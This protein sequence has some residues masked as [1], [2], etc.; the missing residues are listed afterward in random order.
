[1]K[2]FAVVGLMSFLTI[3]LAGCA[4]HTNDYLTHDQAIA[5]IVVPPGVPMINQSSYYSVPPI[6]PQNAS[7]KNPSL[8]PPTLL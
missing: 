8:K 6:P 4:S 1:M 7:Q 3:S 2:R 5:P